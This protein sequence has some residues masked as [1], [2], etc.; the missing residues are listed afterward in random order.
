[1]SGNTR[2]TPTQRCSHRSARYPRDALSTGLS[3]EAT[4]SHHGQLHLDRQCSQ[5][6][7]AISFA[8]T[9]HDEP[10]LNEYFADSLST[11]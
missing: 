9:A 2:S 4:R 3:V 8:W 7:C 5:V 11:K 6:P 10:S 1:M